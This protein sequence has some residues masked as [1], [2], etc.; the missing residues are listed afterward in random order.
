MSFVLC[1]ESC[2]TSHGSCVMEQISLKFQSAYLIFPQHYFFQV[3]RTI[4]RATVFDPDTHHSNISLSFSK[5]ITNFGETAKFKTTI[6][7]YF[8]QDPIMTLQ[9]S[10]NSSTYQTRSCFNTGIFVF[11]MCTLKGCQTRHQEVRYRAGAVSHGS[12][13]VGRPVQSERGGEGRP[14]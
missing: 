1:H 6:K 8:I 14:V 7:F 3:D 12:L 13:Q 9:D 11:L 4:T 2:V 5:V 10:S